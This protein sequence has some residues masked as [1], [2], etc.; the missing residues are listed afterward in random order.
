[1]FIASLNL[2]MDGYGPL[3]SCTK[4]DKE[5]HRSHTPQLPVVV[6]ACLAWM[7]CVGVCVCVWNIYVFPSWAFFPKATACSTQ[8]LCLLRNDGWLVTSNWKTLFFIYVPP[9]PAI[10]N[11]GHFLL[12]GYLNFFST[13]LLLWR[14]VQDSACYSRLNTMQGHN[15]ICCLNFLCCPNSS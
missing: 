9:V 14:I 5:K 8:L 12:G 7:G 11:A 15:L 10:L 4:E 1:M 3:K 6:R 13:F 2:F